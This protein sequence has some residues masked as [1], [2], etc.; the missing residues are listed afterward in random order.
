[1]QPR[2]DLGLHVIGLHLPTGP[3]GCAGC[4][5]FNPGMGLDLSYHLTQVL[6][7][8]SEFN[9]FPGE[10]QS[11]QEALFGMKVGHSSRSWCLYSQARPGFIRH[12]AS[13]SPGSDGQFEGTTRFVFD[14]GGAFDYNTSPRSAIRFS[15]GTNLVRYATH[16]D[17]HQ[18]PVSVLSNE[19]V[20]TQG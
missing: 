15:L 9:I 19:F 12:D 4:A 13:S 7:L 20:A 8:S 6:Y 1:N 16:P 18:P 5:K 14:L 11:A 3:K 17:M 2:W 10:K